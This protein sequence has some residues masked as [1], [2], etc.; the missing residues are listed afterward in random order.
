MPDAPVMTLFHGAAGEEDKP[1]R[2][3]GKRTGLPV[4]DAA[5][6]PADSTNEE[7]PMGTVLRFGFAGANPAPEITGIE[8]LGGHSNY[9]LGKDPAKW[10]TGIPHYRRVR[11]EGLYPGI[12]LVL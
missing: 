9:F 11:A 2:G 1:R 3:N 8:P 6:P 7:Q 5:P 12:A 4:A 10:H